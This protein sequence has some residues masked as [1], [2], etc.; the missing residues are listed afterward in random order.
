M[1]TGSRGYKINPSVKGLTKADE[2]TSGRTPAVLGAEA[3]Q[4][5]TCGSTPMR[6]RPLSP[7]GEESRPRSGH[8]RCGQE[9]LFTLIWAKKSGQ[10]LSLGLQIFWKPRS[11][12]RLSSHWLDMLAM[13]PLGGLRTPST[14]NPGVAP[15]S[16]QWHWNLDDDVTACQTAQHDPKKASSHGLGL[17]ELNSRR[18][19]GPC[20]HKSEKSPAQQRQVPVD[21]ACAA[22]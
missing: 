22:E 1:R 16:R 4:R 14:L 15:D 7:L 21:D 8:L 10:I 3:A 12:V 6:H 20:R 9:P 11:D 18:R 19:I 17:I 2:I 13:P 5:G